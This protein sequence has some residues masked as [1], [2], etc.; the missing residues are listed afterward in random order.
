MRISGCPRTMANEIEHHLEEAEHAKHGA[1]S[2]FDRRVAT[3]MAI[4]AAVLATVTM[5]SHRAHNE[6]LRLQ[7]ESNSLQTEAGIR[8]VQASNNWAWYQAKRL[9]QAQYEAYREQLP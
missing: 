8:Q 2:P 9:R 6:T 1:H 4:V 3:S 5:L 7:A